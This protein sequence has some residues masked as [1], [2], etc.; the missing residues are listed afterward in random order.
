MTPVQVMHPLDVDLL[1]DLVYEYP[2]LYFGQNGTQIKTKYCRKAWS[3]IGLRLG[4]SGRLCKEVWTKKYHDF[5]NHLANKRSRRTN[6]VY[7]HEEKMMFLLSRLEP[8][9]YGQHLLFMEN[10]DIE[11]YDSL[12][13][14]LKTTLTTIG[15]IQ[16]L[17]EHGN[18]MKLINVFFIMKQQLPKRYSVSKKVIEETLDAILLLLRECQIGDLQHSYQLHNFIKTFL[19][20]SNQHLSQGY[21]IER[22]DRA[23]PGHSQSKSFAVMEKLFDDLKN[24]KQYY[25][26]Y[27]V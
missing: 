16:K 23:F 19:T 2:I 11:D 25:S 15:Q 18:L 27:F 24:L 6:E 10:K 17:E 13:T 9:I 3:D 4:Y 5:I 26:S 8:H 21:R 1:I 20:D 14:L 12:T 7:E 22:M